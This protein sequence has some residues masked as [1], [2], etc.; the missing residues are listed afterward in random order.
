MAAREASWVKRQVSPLELFFDLVFVLA[1]GQLTHHLLA[2]LTWHGAAQTLIMLV[3]VCGVWTFTSFEVTLLDIERPATRAVTIAVMGLGLFMNA[4]IAHAFDDGPWLFALPL[5]AALV[6]PA[7][8]ASSTAPT[9]HLREHF[10][11][12]LVWVGAST[13]LWIAGGVLDPQAR[14]WLWAAAA[15]ID[16]VGTFFEH[17]LPGRVAHTENLPFDADHMLER[18]RLFLIIVLGETVLS[19]GRAVSEDHSDPLTLFAALGGFVALVSLWF[20]YFGR[21]EQVAVSHASTVDDP[22][23]TIHLGINVIY[24][25]VTGLVVFATG[26][27]LVI[28]HPEQTR[29]GPGAV[30]L[31]GGPILYLGAQAIYFAMTT[32]H[33]WRPRVA[34]AILLGIGA[35]VAY[36][37]PAMLAVGLL[38]VVL[39]ALAIHLSRERGATGAS[40]TS[41]SKP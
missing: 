13:P 28:A 8:Y 24:G 3:A 25:V 12:V 39:L 23:R 31:L 29:A 15:A 9:A 33:Q 37:I 34:G 38:V 16:L 36:W 27:E 14:L 10:R 20:I 41:T 22:V 7:V 18:M 17:P 4:G 40:V 19:I 21:A 30:L 2:H 5:L 11:R 6:G 26:A 1:I 32:G 35:S